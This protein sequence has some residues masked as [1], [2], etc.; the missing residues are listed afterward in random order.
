MGLRGGA[1]RGGSRGVG[2]EAEL[3]RRFFRQGEVVR[4][5]VAVALLQL[6]R[7]ARCR[8]A[9]TNMIRHTQT[10]RKQYFKLFMS[11]EYTVSIIKEPWRT[12]WS[13]VIT[14]EPFKQTRQCLFSPSLLE[15]KTVSTIE[16]SQSVAREGRGKIEHVPSGRA[17]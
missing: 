3:L 13:K 2:G 17:L 4:L 8:D 9:Q 6:P 15:G 14:L 7:L 10:S 12:A 5:K 11:L 16:P 1:G